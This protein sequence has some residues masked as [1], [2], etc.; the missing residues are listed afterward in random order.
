M[1][2]ACLAAGIHEHL[3]E[4]G[5]DLPPWVFTKQECVA[6]DRAMLK[7]IGSCT[8][9]ERPLR[10]MRAGN[11]SNS[12][13]TIFWATVYA[14]WCF[15]GKGNRV[16]IDNICDIFDIIASLGATRLN[17]KHVR[18][19]LKPRLIN[20]MV[21]RAGLLPPTECMMTLHELLHVCDQ[22]KE[23]GVPRVSSLYKF[24]R[25]NHILKEL[26]KNKARGN[27]VSYYDI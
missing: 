3:T 2:E 9:E 25:M 15:R 7:I 23:I 16:Y 22:V 26:L 11:A 5:N 8:F 12:H 13:D 24:E 27:V 14:R 18:D 20:A 4:N 1:K 21:H 19:I 17:V 6:A 10:V